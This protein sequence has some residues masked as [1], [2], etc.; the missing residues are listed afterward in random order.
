MPN[1]DMPASELEAYLPDV[2]EPGDFDAFWGSTLEESRAAASDPIRTPVDTPLRTLDV[3]DLT[4]SGFAGEPV[5]AW[6]TIP[7]EI[8]RPL[9][10]VVQFNGYGGGRGLAAEH[11][12]WASAGYAHL[13]M[14]TR[15][16]GGTW[17]RAA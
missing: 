15:G 10:A 3:F 16:Q 1:F 4:F 9:P 7:K 12:R 17:G 5:R 2:R 11:L 14:D 8:E 6:L 13:F